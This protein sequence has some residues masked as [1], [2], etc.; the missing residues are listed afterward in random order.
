MRRILRGPRLQAKLTIGA[1]DDAYEREAD[2]VADAVMR[3]PEPRVQ[4]APKCNAAACSQAEEETIQAK[5]ISDQ[6]TPLV[7][8]QIEEDET[9]DLLQTKSA[10]GR[11]P[12]VTSHVASAIASMQGGG[13]PLPEVERAFFEPR[14]GHDFSAVR[15]HTGS[16][17]AKT[18]RAVNAKA[19]TVG[20]DIVFGAGSIRRGM[21]RAD[22]F[23]R[24]N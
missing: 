12:A 13:Q 7:Q 23:W 2:R 24:M 18:A 6:I 11:I 21:P 15:I 8:R 16:Q 3:M 1:P 20:R 14:Y 9:E 19:F 5:P 4:A 22:S 10:F 17:A